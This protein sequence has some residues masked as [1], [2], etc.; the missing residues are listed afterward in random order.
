MSTGSP[1][2]EKALGILMAQPVAPK[3]PAGPQG[4]ENCGHAQF[5]RTP[6]G[7]IKA[8]ESGRCHADPSFTVPASVKV[9]WT[10][11]GIWPGDGLDCPTWKAREA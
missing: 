7:R 3:A 2:L 11:N 1:E 4:C 5:S 8:K 10:K 9:S 6:T